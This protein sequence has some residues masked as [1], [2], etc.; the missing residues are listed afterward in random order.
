MFSLKNALR[1]AFALR[2]ATAPEP[3][4]PKPVLPL[5]SFQDFQADPDLVEAGRLI[6]EGKLAAGFAGLSRL[7]AKRVPVRYDDY[8]RAI[9]FMEDN[10]RDAAIQVLKEE[11]CFFPN[12]EL[13]AAAVR[14]LRPD[15]PLSG[16]GD[17]EFQ[18]LLKIVRPYTMVGEARLLSLF[19]LARQVCQEDL[20]GHFVE[21]GVAAG[22]SS[23]LLAAVVA[24]YSRRPRQ[25]FSFDSFEGM[26]TPSDQDTHC[27][28]HAE[29]AGWGAG[30]CARSEERR[31]GK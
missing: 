6:A 14:R 1:G 20:P 11:L 28:Q 4:T 29:A 13:A 7:K 2:R 10:Q 25:L 15:S 26:P 22:G 19:T 8:L 31:V 18:D 23:G 16:S 3:V 21:C 24:R 30:T 5:P 9:C 27:G 12:N 17:K